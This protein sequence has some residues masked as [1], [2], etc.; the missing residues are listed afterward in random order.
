MPQSTRPRLFP[1]VL[2]IFSLIILFASVVELQNIVS[3]QTSTPNP[4]R[5]IR[6]TRLRNPAR[7]SGG[8]AGFDCHWLED[9]PLEPF[10]D[11]RDSQWSNFGVYLVR[12]DERTYP[13]RSAPSLNAPEIG[14]ITTD[15]WAYGMGEFDCRE[16]F[17]WQRAHY[18]GVVG[19]ITFGSYTETFFDLANDGDPES[20]AEHANDI[21]AYCESALIQPGD[22]IE[23]EALFPAGTRYDIDLETF[24]FVAVLELVS[25]DGEVFLRKESIE[26]DLFGVLGLSRPFTAA[27]DTTLYIRITALDPPPETTPQESPFYKLTVFLLGDYSRN[28]LSM[29]MP[30]F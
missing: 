17:R 30:E 13:I 10:G 16:G 22:I 26:G 5:A 11:L 12:R 6:R 4:T 20:V 8:S 18:E 27:D 29:C 24:G 28:I 25:Q 15:D 14:R 23:Y 9:S 21:V 7:I 3:A 19:W 2:R 1:I